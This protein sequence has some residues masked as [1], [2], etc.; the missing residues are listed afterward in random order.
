MQYI[1][2]LKL[3]AVEQLCDAEERSTEYMLQ[4]M[5]DTC[6]VTLDCTLA[7]LKITSKEKEKLFK[8]V[9]EFAELFIILNDE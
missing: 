3:A 5:Q 2:K 8:E 9:V 1:T 4:L 7:Y 6:K